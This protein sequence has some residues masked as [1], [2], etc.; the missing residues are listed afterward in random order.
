M[1]CDDQVH[2]EIVRR[3]RRGEGAN[4]HIHADNEAN[5]GGR[6]ALNDIAAHVIAFTNPVRHMEIACA[7]AE[8]NRRLQNDDGHG[9]VHVVIAVDQDGLLALDCGVDAIDRDA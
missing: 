7:A 8:F 3:L 4:A 2:S 5:A 9:A 6:G 1:V